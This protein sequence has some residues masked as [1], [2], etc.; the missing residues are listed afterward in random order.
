MRYDTRMTM[1][2]LALVLASGAAIAQ[3][4]S[5]TSPKPTSP[6]PEAKPTVPAKPIEG[7]ITM[8]SDSTVLASTLIGAQVVSPAGQDMASIKD[9]IVKT[10]GTIDGVVIGVGGFLG[11]GEHSVAVKW[12]KIQLKEA[13]AKGV[14]LV[15]TASKEDLKAA[16]PFKSK[17]QM[18]SDRK[19]A[20]Q[21]SQAPTPRAPPAPK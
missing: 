12:D 8:Q 1:A 2:T 15:L 11:I 14:Q 18:E 6:A 3:T 10:D 21:R 7:H 17:T 16:E 9:V 4:P 20:E 5:P 19:A 13:G